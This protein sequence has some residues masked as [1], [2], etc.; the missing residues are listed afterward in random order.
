MNLKEAEKIYMQISIE[1]AL[2]VIDYYD[3]KANLGNFNIPEGFIEMLWDFTVTII[4]NNFN[5][6][7]AYNFKTVSYALMAYLE[8]NE[9]DDLIDN[10]FPTPEAKLFKSPSYDFVQETVYEYNDLETTYE[11]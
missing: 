4:E 7:E 8:E 11:I 1:D 9:M 10:L 3:F 2:T 6:S 5:L